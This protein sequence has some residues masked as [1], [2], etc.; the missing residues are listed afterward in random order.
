MG[1]LSSKNTVPIILLII[2]ILVWTSVWSLFRI[3]I[4]AVPPLSFRVIIG[5]P[6]FVLLLILGFKKV[7]TINVPKADWKPLLLISFFNVTLWQVLMLYGISML[8]GGRAAVLT[9]TMP[10]WATIFA[11]IFGYE[12]INLSI[13]ISL[14]FGMLGIFFLS[15]EINIFQN[16]V[17]FLITLSAGLSWAVGTMIVKYGGIKSDGLIVAGWQQI[18]GI[19]PIIPFALYFDSNNFGSIDY[20][21]ISIILYGIFLS[22]AYTYWAYFT[23]LQ[24][25]SVNVTSISVMAVPIL[26]ILV[27]YVFIN[28]KFSMFDLL[29]LIFIVTGIYIVAKK[30]FNQTKKSNN[31]KINNV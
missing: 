27:D 16:M 20:I 1:L 7:K 4:E 24:K 13:I 22:S 18:I 8:G 15:I 23:I 5:I 25:I 3:V 28:I 11:A 31:S 2:L 10:V 14:I 26:A 30:P 19:I 17:G 9:Y 29:A 21:H 12:K 6:A